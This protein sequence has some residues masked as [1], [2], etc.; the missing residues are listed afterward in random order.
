MLK[1]YFKKLISVLGTVLMWFAVSVI[2]GMV[3]GLV[4][5]PGINYFAYSMCM[6]VSG[7]VTVLVVGK[8]KFS[9]MQQKREYLTETQFQKMKFLREIL[10]I[11][12]SKAFIS[13][14]AA[15]ATLLVPLMVYVCQFPENADMSL[16]R[17][18]LTSVVVIT[19][20]T[21]AFALLDLVVSLIVRKLWMKGY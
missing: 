15:F 16:S 4:Q 6:V 7:V 11:L 13:E 2:V 10:N 14:L 21:A 9:D 5:K 12:K 20:L 17:L 18:I 3:C 1:L 19:E 8:L